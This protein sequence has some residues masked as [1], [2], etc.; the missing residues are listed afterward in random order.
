MRDARIAIIGGGIGGLTAAQALRQRGFDV[1]VYGAPPELKEI[2][3]GA[4]LGPNAMKAL[5]ALDLEQP[6]RDAAW[7]AEATTLLTGRARG[8][9]H[10]RLQRQPSG[11]ALRR[12]RLLRPPRRPARRARPPRCP[13]TSSR[14]GRAVSPCPA[15]AMLRSAASATARRS[16]PTR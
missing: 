3:A 1:A 6:V 7:E 14:S 4:A 9:Y 8:A 10:G 13:P 2:G 12:G 11:R 15:T 16:R 5:R